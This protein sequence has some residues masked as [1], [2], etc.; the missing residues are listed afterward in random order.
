MLLTSF[1]S[2]QNVTISFYN[3]GKKDITTASFI[4]GGGGSLASAINER[5]H[6]IFIKRSLHKP[7]R[8]PVHFP[9]QFGQKC[10]PILSRFFLRLVLSFPRIS[11]RIVWQEFLVERR[12][13]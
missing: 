13:W 6:L 7:V 12:D 3:N 2:N 8:I 4:L 5:L 11:S 9:V 10:F 1:H